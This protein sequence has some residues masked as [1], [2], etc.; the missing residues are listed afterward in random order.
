MIGGIAIFS[1][2]H[3][4]ARSGLENCDPINDNVIVRMTEL[5]LAILI[6]LT[7]KRNSD[8]ALI[9]MGSWGSAND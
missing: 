5:G 7:S 4:K 1:S 6:E 3:L 9:A 2:S 8:R